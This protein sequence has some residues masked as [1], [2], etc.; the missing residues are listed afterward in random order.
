MWKITTS[1]DFWPTLFMTCID[2]CTHGEVNLVGGSHD[3]E[4]NVQV[5]VN[6]SWSYICQ[7]GW[8]NSDSLVACSEL[9]YSTSS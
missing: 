6:G 1:T 8:D 3:Y 9:G 7:S 4:G 5:C 2:N